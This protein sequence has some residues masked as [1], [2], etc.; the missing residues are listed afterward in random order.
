MLDTLTLKKQQSP[1]QESRPRSKRQCCFGQLCCEKQGDAFCFPASMLSSSISSLGSLRVPGHG[2]FRT[3]LTSRP[4]DRYRKGRTRT[5]WALLPWSCSFHYH[6]SFLKIPNS[7]WKLMTL[8]AAREYG[9]PSHW[10]GLAL[11]L[12]EVKKQF[13]TILMSVGLSSRSESESHVKLMIASAQPLFKDIKGGGS[14]KP[15]WEAIRPEK[16]MHRCALMLVAQN[17]PQGP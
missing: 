10:S 12:T 14:E 9:N 3:Q 11:A 2:A 5:L 8:R 6:W 7:A 16:S 4:R 17:K 15:S 1:E 13:L